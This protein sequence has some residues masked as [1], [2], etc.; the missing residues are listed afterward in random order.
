MLNTLTTLTLTKKEVVKLL[1]EQQ[2]K[3]E[4]EIWNSQKEI[5]SLRVKVNDLEIENKELTKKYENL[6]I[7]YN[8]I[9]ENFLFD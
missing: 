8:S 9:R 1:V 5:D 2:E 6:K 4:H 3:H 7:E